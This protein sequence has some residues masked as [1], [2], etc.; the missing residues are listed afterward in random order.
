MESASAID[1]GDLNLEKPNAFGPIVTQMQ[2]GTMGTL[3]LERFAEM[4]E[5]ESIVF[6]HSHPGI[7]RTGNLF[8]GWKTGSWGMW[9]AAVVM[10]PILMMVAYSFQESAERHVYQITGGAFGGT[11]PLV[12]GVEGTTTRGEKTGGLFLVS[13]KCDTVMNEKE[14]IK[15]RAKAQEAVWEKALDVT[16]PYT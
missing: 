11:G 9:F 2:M 1:V 15:L 14:M 6:I 3:A 12:S 5:N 8:R 4:E 13:R 10:D 16:G 7:V